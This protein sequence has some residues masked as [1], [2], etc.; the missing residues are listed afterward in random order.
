MEMGTGCCGFTLQAP[1]LRRDLVM[2]VGFVSLL[3]VSDRYWGPAAALPGII[4]KG[5]GGSVMPGPVTIPRG[6][7]SR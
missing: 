5:Q 6:A 4:Q 3:A 1:T 7:R 2:T